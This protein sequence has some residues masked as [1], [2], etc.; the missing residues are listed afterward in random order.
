MMRRIKSW[1]LFL[2]D[3]VATANASTTGG[4][5][6]VANATVG[7]LPGVGAESGSGDLGMTLR[8]NGKRKKGDPSEVSDLR[9]LE[10]AEIEVVDDIKE[11][12]TDVD[13]LFKD[14]KNDFGTD[15]DRGFTPAQVRLFRKC[16]SIFNRKFIKN[17]VKVVVLAD[18]LGGV[19]AQWSNDKRLFRLNPRVFGFKKKMAGVSYPEFVIMHELSHCVDYQERISFGSEWRSLSGWK[20]CGLDEKVPEGYFRYVELRPG[21]EKAGHKKSDW[22]SREGS[23]FCRKY[24]SRNPREDFADSMAFFILGDM[25][26]FESDEGKRKL[27]IV[28]RVLKRVS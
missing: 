19:R 5:G 4:A 25:S 11:S 28:K 7:S 8:S 24:S 23:S 3:G 9:D 12:A 22:I 2:E 21:R 20:K 13:R 6:G 16:F 1:S 15:L 26:K 14:F 27:E 17:K 18:D 10:K